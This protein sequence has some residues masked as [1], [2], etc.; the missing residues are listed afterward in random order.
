MIVRDVMVKAVV[1]LGNQV[2]DVAIQ[3][4]GIRK[5]EKGR[6]GY[7]ETVIGF[8]GNANE[9]QRWSF[10]SSGWGPEPTHKEPH[11]VMLSHREALMQS[12]SL[13]LRRVN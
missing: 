13:L 7:H 11:H 9:S 12:I 6:V 5:F 4:H 3:T 8:S 10:D 1:V 2:Q